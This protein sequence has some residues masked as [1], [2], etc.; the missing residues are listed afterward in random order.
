MIGPRVMAVGGYVVQ[1]KATVTTLPPL[2]AFQGRVAASA[3]APCEKPR[4]KVRQTLHSD[5]HNLS[6]IAIF[7][8]EEV[9]TRA[10]ATYIETNT[11]SL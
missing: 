2:G 10:G 7:F 1:D 3:A 5:M 6:K 8:S 4:Y 11:T 9:E